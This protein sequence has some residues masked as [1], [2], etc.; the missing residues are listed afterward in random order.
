MAHDGMNARRVFVVGSLHLDIMLHAP[1]LPR[2]D[3][4]VMGDSVAY[5]FGGKGG[6]QAL[7]AAQMGA[8][9]S[10]AGRVGDDAFGQQLLDRL[11]VSTVDRTQVLRR[12]GA[13]GMSAAIVDAAGDYGAVVVSG[14][15]Q[16]INPSD[17]AMPGDTA[18]LMLQ[19]EVPEAVN[20]SIASA[21]FRRGIPVLLNAA[22]ARDLVPDLTRCL[23][24]L[25]VNRVEAEDLTGHSDPDASARALSALG[26]PRVLVTLGGDGVIC[27]D[28]DGGDHFPGHPVSVVSSHGAGDAFVGAFAAATVAGEAARTAIAFA[29]AA[30]ALHVSTPVQQRAR[31]PPEQVRAFLS[32]HQD[33]R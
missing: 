26:I 2:I 25:V 33:R 27:A 8:V 17:I 13:S 9:V 30:A 5:A 14:S 10:M 6:N 4:T 31:I 32:D 20:L 12:P 28:S 24:T 29:Q 1:N 23:T 3:E 7:A 21:A 16:H 15:N 22:P 19:N 11:D 18:L